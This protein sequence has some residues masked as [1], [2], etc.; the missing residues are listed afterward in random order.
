VATPE[1]IEIAE[2]FSKC[3]LNP[4][5][6]NNLTDRTGA[7]DVTGQFRRLGQDLKGNLFPQTFP[8]P[9]RRTDHSGFS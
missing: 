6:M 2:G 8:H 7:C 9:A 4:F 1:L 3:Y 5:A